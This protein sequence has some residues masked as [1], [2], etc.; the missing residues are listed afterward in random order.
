MIIPRLSRPRQALTEEQPRTYYAAEVSKNVSK[1][2]YPA[3]AASSG[4]EKPLKGVKTL[5]RGS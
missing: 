2:E 4:R 5:I 1:A 3:G